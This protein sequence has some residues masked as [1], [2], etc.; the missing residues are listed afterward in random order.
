MKPQREHATNNDQTYMATSSTWERHSLLQNEQCARLLIDT[1]DHYRPSA[2]LLHEFVIMPD[3]F[4]PL[5]RTSNRNEIKGAAQA[6][7]FQNISEAATLQRKMKARSLQGEKLSDP[8]EA[9]P[10]LAGPRPHNAKT[11]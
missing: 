2:Y 6:A 11:N 3:H 7:P 4:H 5:N 9:V 10:L 8:P 1:L